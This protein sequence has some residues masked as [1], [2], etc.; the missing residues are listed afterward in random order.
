M[1]GR[2]IDLEKGHNHTYWYVKFIRRD[3]YWIRQL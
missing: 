3:I 2:E 1:S